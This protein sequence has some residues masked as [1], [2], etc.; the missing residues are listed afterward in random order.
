M[1]PVLRLR[2]RKPL[3]LGSDSHLVVEINHPYPQTLSR[4]DLA[5]HS[6]L[7]MRGV[8]GLHQGY[9]KES[10]SVYIVFVRKL[11]CPVAV[12]CLHPNP[13]RVGDAP[14]G[15]MG[16]YP[17]RVRMFR[18]CKEAETSFASLVIRTPE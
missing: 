7:D 12:C 8:G 15:I 1:T 2:N 18:T 6:G 4:S 14:T 11:H 16:L 9:R 13:F 10:R 5:E 3:Y 17:A